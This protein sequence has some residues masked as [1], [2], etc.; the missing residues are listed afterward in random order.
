MAQVLGGFILVFLLASGTELAVGGKKVNITQ[1]PEYRLRQVLFSSHDRMVRP[2]STASQAVN[3]TFQLDFKG[4]TG[5]DNKEQVITTETVIKQVWYNPF[6]QWEA[7][8]YGGIT[9]IFVEPKTVWIPDVVLENN[10]DNSVVQAGHLEKFRTYVIV[11]NDGKNAWIS[12]A[13]FKSSCQ[14]DVQYFPFDKQKCNML[15]RSLT[16]DSRMLDITT[17]EIKSDNPQ[18]DLNLNSSNGYWTLRSI[19]MIN[20]KVKKEGQEFSEVV[21]SFFIGRRPLFFVLFSI[22]PCMIIGL[23]ILVSFFIP[24]ED[25]GRISFCATILLAVSVYLLAVTKQLPEQSVTLPL[26]G[27]YYTVIMFEIGLALAAT[28]LVLKAHH[29]T[30][31]P[32]KFLIYLTIIN[33]I[34]CR[35]RFWR[36]KKTDTPAPATTDENNK[37]CDDEEAGQMEMNAPRISVAFSTNTVTLTEANQET[38]KEIA[39]ALDRVFFWVFLA[40]IVLSSF[41]IYAHAGQLASDDNF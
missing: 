30:S 23:L 8:D 28:V 10:V 4:L 5:V 32:P 19:A 39:R 6:F 33:D 9:Q 17:M 25:G 7:S 35:K 16:S 18:K 36:P 31:E 13:T 37:Q 1:E 2:V 26:I 21:V 34:T 20:V 29:A 38:W 3:V 40:L 27:V 12:P 22:V 15:F 14:L 41:V 24:A 11:Q